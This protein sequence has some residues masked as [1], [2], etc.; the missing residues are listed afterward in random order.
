MSKELLLRSI[1]FSLTTQFTG[2][3]NTLACLLPTSPAGSFQ[4]VLIFAVVY[5]YVLR[6]FGF[7]DH[8][9]AALSA[10]LSIMLDRELLK[11]TCVLGLLFFFNN[12]IPN[13]MLSMNTSVLL[14]V[15]PSPWKDLTGGEKRK[16]EPWCINLIFLL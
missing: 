14:C 12:L 5:A 1:L 13:E 15:P 10:Y 8:I 9:K 3:Q 4:E 7:Q 16:G 6:C 11:Q 2:Q